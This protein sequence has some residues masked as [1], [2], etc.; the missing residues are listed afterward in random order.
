[1]LLSSY[2]I[3]SKLPSRPKHSVYLAVAAFVM[4]AFV[5]APAQALDLPFTPDLTATGWKVHTPSGKTA[6]LFTVEGSGGLTVAASQAVAFLYCFIP[7]EGKGATLLSWDWRV[8]Q[9]FVGTDLSQPG[10][11]D[12]PIAVHVYFTDQKSGLLKR[13]GRGLAGLFGVPVS[14]RAITYVWG[15]QQPPGTMIANPFMKTGEGVLMVLQSSMPTDAGAWKRET[16]DLAADYRAAFG[17]A[18]SPVS[19]IAVSADTDDTGAS[20]VAQ[21]RGLTLLPDSTTLVR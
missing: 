5:A 12:R 7:D 1:M 4:W 21:I 10:A 8:T 13:M 18:P 14:G 17:E 19:V 11:D 15:G 3:L 6:A 9:D 20:A 16:V 2:L